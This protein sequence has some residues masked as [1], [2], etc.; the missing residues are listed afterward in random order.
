MPR[1]AIFKD[2][3]EKNNLMKSHQDLDKILKLSLQNLNTKKTSK[4]LIRS[5]QDLIR[6][7]KTKKLK[8]LQDQSSKI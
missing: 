8:I 4:S 1:S 2:I 3:L 5:Y 7:Y 6:L